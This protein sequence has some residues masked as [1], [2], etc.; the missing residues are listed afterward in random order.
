[1]ANIPNLLFGR[2]LCEY[3]ILINLFFNYQ[4]FEKY[5]V[6]MFSR[7]HVQSII[8]HLLCYEKLFFS[9]HLSLSPLSLSLSPSLSHLSFQLISGIHCCLLHHVFPCS[10]QASTFR[11]VVRSLIFVSC[12]CTTNLYS[13]LRQ[14]GGFRTASPSPHAIDS[15]I[16]AL[17]FRQ[18]AP[19]LFVFVICVI[20]LV[21][22]M[23][24]LSIQ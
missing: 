20:S 4:I 23:I 6:N 15:V 16:C 10:D 12:I 11:Q 17:A 19:D 7:R 3:S 1:M 2:T 14:D 24:I 21:F 22:H 8:D 13:V 9:L 5:I 18:Y